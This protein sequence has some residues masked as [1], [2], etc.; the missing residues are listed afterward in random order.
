MYVRDALHGNVY[1][2]G[3][4]KDIIDT[5]SFQRLV[6]IRQLAFAYLVYPGATNTRLEHS[7]GTMHVAKE[8]AK[9][10]FGDCEE[11]L[12]IAGLVHDI[13]HPAFSHASE[14]ALRKYLKEDH[15]K[16]SI[17]I[18]KNGDISEVLEKFKIDKKKVLGFLRG[19][20]KGDII[21]G[22][23]GADRIDY[24]MRDSLHIG[25]AYGIIDY[26]RIK[27]K[28]LFYDKKLSI[29]EEGLQ[30]A[31]SLLIARYFMYETVYLHHTVRIVE[32]M[33]KKALE[34]AI[35]SGKFDPKE[36]YG[37]DYTIIKRLNEI[38][39]SKF[40]MNKII[41]RKL[42]KRVYYANVK[43]KTD[44]EEIKNAL[45]K[46]G[47]KKDEFVI[48]LDNMGGHMEN[49]PVVNKKHDFIGNLNE[50]SP[51]INTLENIM[52]NKNTLIVAVEKS[53]IEKA[54][55]VLQKVL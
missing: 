25:V 23:L 18:I 9:N 13:G 35:E 49:I 45:E 14:D 1:L 11:E 21:S 4:E 6:Y 38:E 32:N 8:L 43:E 37:D 52:K 53:R 22:S 55:R 36:L 16:R 51:L 47:I 20:N 10:M 5:K 28:L 44:L 17:E 26:N 7:I 33:Y 27:N 42:F 50:V 41:E 19:K 29:Y 31:E 3:V 15:E 40:I 54:K 30:G 24:L 2:N 12:A 46:A 48:A 39:E 34:L